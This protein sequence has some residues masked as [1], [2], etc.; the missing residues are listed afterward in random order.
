MEQILKGK[1]AIITGSGQGVGREIALCFAAHGAKVITNNRKPGS[2][3]HAFEGIELNFTPEERAE[4]LCFNGDAQTVAD[5]I[6]AAGGEALPVYGDVSKREDAKRMVDAAIEKWGRVDIIVNNASS[7][8]TG[9]I[10]DMDPDIFDTQIASK[11]NGSFYLMHYA[12]PHMKEQGFGRIINTA[13]DAIL[14]VSGLAAYGAANG[15][16]AVLTKACANDLK[17]TGITVNAYTPLARTRSWYNARTNYRLKGIPV[18]AVEANAPEAMKRTAEGMVPFLA[19]LC[20]DKGA[21]I[22]GKLFHLA[23]DGELGLWNEYA[24]VKTIKQAEGIWSIE[25]LDKRV[26]SELLG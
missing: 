16:I 22:S 13:S 1:V 17:G 23:A 4:L 9:S 18:E 10:L 11:L 20:S 25:E 6:T 7:N 12:M 24:I 5:E 26:N 15:G 2:S 14:G 8:W 3:I 19:W 21:D